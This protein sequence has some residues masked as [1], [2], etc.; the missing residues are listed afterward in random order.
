MQ[1]KAEFV[2]T[3]ADFIFAASETIQEKIQL[4][5]PNKEIELLLHG[6]DFEHFSVPVP[7]STEISQ[8]RSKGLPVAGYFGSL[9]DANDK[10]VFLALANNGFSVVIIGQILGDYSELK[11]HPN[12]YF[13][14]PVKY[15][16]LPSWA[17]GF[18]VAL[19]NWR[20]HDWIENCFPVKTLEYLACGLPIVSCKIPSLP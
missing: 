16:L 19:L 20:M 2:C 1:Q 9:S 3:K 18:D 17:Q 11:E 6:V 7:L 12:I 8:I 5:A 14:G 13:I 15:N 4:I 10:E